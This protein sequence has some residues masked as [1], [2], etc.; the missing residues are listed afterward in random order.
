MP[1]VDKRYAEALVDVA[2]KNNS[3]E[4]TQVELRVF[5]QMYS[6]QPEFRRFFNAP[7]IGNKEKKDA[8]KKIFNDSNSI[9]L[10]FLQLLLDKGRIN[11]LPGIFR[12]YVD[13]ADKR[14][15]VLHLHI[16]TA[17]AIDEAQLEK[18]KEKYKAEYN[19]AKD[20]TTI[21]VDPELIGG[22]VVQ[23]GD[24]VIDGSIKGR[25]KGLKEAIEK[26]QYHRAI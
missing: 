21:T 13:I 1:L 9:V 2:E 12:E 15:N 16:K 19:A 6:Q 26:T 10:P 3:L 17:V 24:R 23:I 8:L 7:E 11:N 20:K 18:I 5:A 14:K 25:L 22:I 4:T